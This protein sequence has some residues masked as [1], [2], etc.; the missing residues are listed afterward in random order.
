MFSFY[1]PMETGEKKFPSPAAPKEKSKHTNLKGIKILLVED[2]KMNQFVGKKVIE[3]KWQ[4]DLTI[5]ETGEEALE[6]I[7]KTTYD[8]ILM[9]LLL[10]GI[11]GYEVTRRIRRG[12]AGDLNS[13]SVPVI[14]FTADAFAETRQKA[15]EAG[16]DDFVSKPFDYFKLFDKIMQ[17]KK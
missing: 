11:S 3:K 7:C 8:L 13:T 10:P 14:A 9:D 4:A 1:L 12:D 5:A 15:Y 2:D 16:V 6:Y 17:Y